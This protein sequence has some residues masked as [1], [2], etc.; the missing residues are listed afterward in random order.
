MKQILSGAADEILDAVEK[1]IAGYEDEWDAVEKTIAGYEEECK[2][3]GDGDNVV[4]KPQIKST[5]P[6][7]SGVYTV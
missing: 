6:T 7:I 4:I 2:M 3:V 5:M 1:T